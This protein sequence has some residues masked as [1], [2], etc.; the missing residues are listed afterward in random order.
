M[1]IAASVMMERAASA[2]G[3][4]FAVPEIIVG[5]LV[6]A[7]VTSMPNAVAAVYLASP[8]RG[9]ATFSTALNSNALNVTCA[10]C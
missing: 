5:G 2:L 6:L 8:G 10:R 1:V 4:R 3:S 9:A 7:A